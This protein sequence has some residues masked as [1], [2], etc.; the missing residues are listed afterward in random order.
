MSRESSEKVSVNSWLEDELYT[1][2]RSDRRAVDDTWKEVFD[3]NG[4]AVETPAAEPPRPAAQPVK[5]GAGE[6]LVPLRGAAARIAENM[7]ASLSVP[8]GHLA[9]HHCRQGD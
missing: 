3:S 8:R 1:Q 2:Y 9:A 5:T 7:Q 4:H 6:E